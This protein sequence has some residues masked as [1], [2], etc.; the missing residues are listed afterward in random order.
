MYSK[1]GEMSAGYVRFL[2]SLGML[3]MA[4]AIV[5]NRFVDGYAMSAFFQGMC[6]GIA[7][8]VLPFSL[9]KMR[10]RIRS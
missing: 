3:C 7:I 9:Y 4:A 2:F 5:L 1:T 8:V 6:T 10:G